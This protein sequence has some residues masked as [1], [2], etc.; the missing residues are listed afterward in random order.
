[1]RIVRLCGMIAVL[2]LPA[3]GCDESRDD[4]GMTPL[5]HAARRGDT[6]E[7]KRL[8]ADGAEIEAK[9]EPHRGLRPMLAF[10]MWMQELPERK[11]GWTP[12]M[13][14]VDSARH[15]AA[16]VLLH[17]GA[18][19]S[20][21][22]HGLTAVDLAVFKH[23]ARMA[24][25]LVER[26]ARVVNSRHHPLM[27]A[28]SRND[29]ALIRMMLARGSAV[30]GVGQGKMTAL[31][32][33]AEAGAADAVDLLLDAHAN[34]D[35]Q[36]PNG[37]RAARFAVEKGHVA[38]ADRLGAS[39]DIENAGLFAAIQSENTDAAFAALAR[40][41]DVNALNEHGRSALME[42]V[43]KLPEDAIF[44]LIDAGARI[45][46]SEAGPMLYLAVVLNY[47][48]LFDRMMQEG[49]TPRDNFIASAVRAGHPDMVKRLL[50]LGL[51]PH[52]LDATGRSGLDLARLRNDKALIALLEAASSPQ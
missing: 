7:V 32:A 52:A 14:A 26:G 35:V 10:I 36:G 9:G 47:P 41:A 33:A 16:R 27:F 43:S 1:M 48:R 13:F 39:N 6:L 8:I 5:M 44:G 42:A 20:I 37:W 51:D 12:L 21:E 19:A 2:A 22:A 3:Y 45:H 30:D 4:H 18:D 38:L 15:D 31:M 49:A 29:T 40:G 50:A 28:A 23:D 11:P 34:P 25:L 24:R 17:H 46:A